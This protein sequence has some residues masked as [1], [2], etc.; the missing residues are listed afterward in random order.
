MI[1]PFQ[2]IKNGREL[3]GMNAADGKRTKCCLLL[4]S[5][6]LFT[7]SDR[8]IHSLGEDYKVRT[9]IDF[10]DISECEVRPDKMI[11]G[12][13]YRQIPIL[14]P[15][16]EEMRNKLMAL[17][18]NEPRATFLRIYENIAENSDAAAAYRKFFQTILEDPGAPVLYHCRQGKDR[19]GIASILLLTALGVPEEEVLKD[20]FLTNELLKADFEALKAEGLPEDQLIR[21]RDILFVTNECIDRYFAV[22]KKNWGG[23]EGYLKGAL[24]LDQNDLKTLRDVYTE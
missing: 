15:Q 13:A 16:P 23:V 17:L 11:P 18:M 3:G 19:T 4:R 1:L 14:P 7:A 9:V 22:L 12:A 21:A 8:E 20:Y 6:E 10:R 2:K 5:G 24:R